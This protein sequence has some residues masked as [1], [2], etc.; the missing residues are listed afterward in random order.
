MKPRLLILGAS[1]PYLRSIE[2]ACEIGCWVLALD[3]NPSAPGLKAADCGEVVDIVDMEGV[4]RAAKKHKIQGILALNDFGVPTAAKVA[5]E[6]GLPGLSIETSLISTSKELMRRAWQGQRFNPDYCVVKN[7]YEAEK[8]VKSLDRFP[9]VFKPTNSLGGGSRG[10]SKVD[11]F[12]Q[13]EAALNFAQSFYATQEVIIEQCVVGLEHSVETITVKGETHIIMISDKEKTLPPY[14]VDK[15]VIYP[16]VVTG[17]LL[18]NLKETVREAVRLVGIVEG[19]AHVELCTTDQ[20]SYVFELGARCGGGGTPHPIC[21]WVCGVEEL[22]E[23]VRLALGQPPKN[24]EPKWERGCV[25]RFLTPPKHG[26]LMSVQ[27]L[28]EIKKWPGILDI[29]IT[30][31]PGEKIRP[32][33]S[34]HDRAGY[35]I[36]GA[37][38]R[39]QAIALADK[40]EDELK[41]VFASA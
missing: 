6:L 17:A 28:E 37:E 30:V 21:P 15:S 14:C 40:A 36:A 11:N 7:L 38:N 13:V 25:Y 35:I 2:T 19:V 16:T 10:V 8:A 23:A 22:V 1:R 3:R 24:L 33:Q 41:F 34:G 5:N 26:T 31:S 39:A 32:V 27:G 9:L 29:D 18:E 20:G 4:L 12:S